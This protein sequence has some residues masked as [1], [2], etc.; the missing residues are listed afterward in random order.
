MSTIFVQRSTKILTKT[1]LALAQRTSAEQKIITKGIA[2]SQRGLSST[3]ESYAGKL[4]NAFETYRREN[5]S[6]DLQSRFRKDIEDAVDADHDGL[7]TVQE[8]LNVLN[9][10]GAR[11]CLSSEQL[12]QMFGELSP[13]AETEHI[14]VDSLNNL[15]RGNR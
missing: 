1:S 7:F 12:H 9:N 4:Y 14:P 10:I 2:A 15:L 13:L 11:D 8:V 6:R 3:S 5:Y